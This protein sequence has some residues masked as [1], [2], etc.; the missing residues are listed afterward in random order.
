MELSFGHLII[1]TECSVFDG[2][3]NAET[4]TDEKLLNPT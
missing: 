4:T 2:S 1:I 3:G